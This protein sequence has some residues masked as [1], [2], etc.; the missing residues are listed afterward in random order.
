MK[1]SINGLGNLS[2]SS[3]ISEAN[4]EK[5]LPEKLKMLTIEMME[6]MDSVE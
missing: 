4:P 3:K 6:S 5:I 1:V 2:F